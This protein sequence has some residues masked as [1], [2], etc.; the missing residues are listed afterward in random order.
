MNALRPFFLLLSRASVFWLSVVGLTAIL[1]TITG[2][3]KPD[4]KLGFVFDAVFLSAFVIP[5]GAGWLAGAVVQE[6]QHTSFAFGLPGVRSRI[7]TGFLTAGLAVTLVVMSGIALSGATPQRLPALFFVSL[8]AYCLGGI[9]FDPLSAWLTGMNGIIVLFVVAASDRAARLS[10]DH[11]WMTIVIAVAVGAVS[12][13][14][15]FARSTFRRK[16]FR[17]TSP[18]PG[19]YSLERVREIEHRRKMKQASSGNGWHAGYLGDNLWRWVRAAVHE[20]RGANGWRSFVRTIAKSWGL[21][22][23]I[24]IYA[25]TDKGEMSLGEAVAR[26]LHDALLRSPH[27]PQFGD[28][29]GPYP[30]VAL[31]IAAAGVASA[32]FSPVAFNEGMSHP[33]SREQ[34]ATVLFRGGL[35]EGAI[36]LFVVA[37]CLFAV[38]QLTGWFV[39]H[40]IHFDFMP[41]FFRVLLI[42]L[43]LMPLVH[44]GRLQLHAA[45]RR[46]AENGMVLVIFGVTGFVV[47]VC[48]C[49]WISA[50]I[51]PAPGAELTVLAVALLVSQWVYR[52]N[53][54]RYYKTADLA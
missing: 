47:A 41:F 2:L 40:E 22:A 37:P 36:F 18:L 46:K 44:R 29:G 3:A 25:W 49:A 9:F 53:L 42:T 54:A 52:S 16:P 5:A 24:L 51:L 35:V 6:F 33:L 26:T 23:L 48:I 31:A 10:A 14:R 38:G 17:L 39:G 8:G 13:Q 50:R 28:D 4:E 43:I 21:G 34:R 1:F 45:T 7:Q 32:L 12:V 20:A 19:F 30:L 27:H 11:P 15:L